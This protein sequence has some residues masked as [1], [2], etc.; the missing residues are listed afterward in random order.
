MKTVL[1]SAT[2]SIKRR[3]PVLL[4]FR[5]K[6]SLTTWE[7]AELSPGILNLGIGQPAL[8]LLPT[9]E[10]HR[11]VAQLSTFDA[12]HLLQYGSIAGSGHYLDATSFFL[13]QQ[14]GYHIP[15]DTLFATPGNSGGLALTV[16]TLTHPGDTMLMEDPSY[17]LAHALFRDYGLSLTAVPQRQDGGGTLDIDA[18]S[19]ILRSLSDEGRVT[20]PAEPSKAAQL[21]SHPKLLYCVPTGNNPRGATMPDADRAA[22]V[23]LCTVHGMTI[24]ADDVYECLQWE[25]RAAPKPLRWHARQQ[26]VGSTVVSLG[27]WSK[28]LGPGL[29][30]G[31]VEAEPALLARFG[32]DGEVHSGSLTSP[33]IECLVTKLLVSGDG[34]AHVVQ[35]REA[36]A[37]RAARLTAAID[38]EQPTGTPSLICP[39]PSAGYFL[40][41]DLRGV[42]ASKLR[43]ACVAR[44]GVS[45]L[46]GP[47]CALPSSTSAPGRAP[48]PW[49]SRGR[50]CFAFLEEEQMVEAGRRLG[51]AIAEAAREASPPS[52]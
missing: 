44:H 26:G 33:F 13:S 50:V 24:V 17:F 48:G 35:L 4:G 16:R 1:Q 6:S 49:A 18:L 19:R 3:Q 23:E 46:P 2:A 7:Q 38:A 32:A 37:R 34:A 45:F 10:V 21:D 28:L 40:W 12:R 14:H 41:V 27:S 5:T 43:E 51:R 42:D 30:L 15:P 52:A 31:W 9:A 11:A 8:S 29:R 25:R 36:L 20:R 47:R 39:S 22:L